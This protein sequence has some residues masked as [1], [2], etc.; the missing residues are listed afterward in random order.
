MR[1]LV[2]VVVVVVAAAAA[3]AAPAFADNEYCQLYADTNFYRIKLSILL[4]SRHN[5]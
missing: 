5:K 2:V 1:R 4:Q 3:A